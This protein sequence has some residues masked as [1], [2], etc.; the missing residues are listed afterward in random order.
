MKG[1][2]G[3]ETGQKMTAQKPPVIA[4]SGVKNSGKT[5]LLEKILPILTAKGLNVAVIKH[6]GHTFDADVEG[7]DSYR[8]RKAGAYGTAVFCGTHYMVI[9]TEPTTSEALQSCFSDADLILC[10]GLKNSCYPK[11]EVVRAGNSDAPVCDPQTLLAVATD[12]LLNLSIPTVDLNNPLK[13]AE[14]IE[15]YLQDQTTKHPKIYKILGNIDENKG[16]HIA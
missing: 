10:E 9:K 8:M 13:I 7:T 4:I 2:I 6:D 12:Q 16:S 3:M 5:T 11:I 1:G 15:R 14:L